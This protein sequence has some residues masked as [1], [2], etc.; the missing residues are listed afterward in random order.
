MKHLPVLKITLLGSAAVLVSLVLWNWQRILERYQTHSALSSPIR[1]SCSR[2][3]SGTI[4]TYLT[5]YSTF[6]CPVWEIGKLR[7]AMPG[8][9]VRILESQIGFEWPPQGR[10]GQKKSSDGV[11]VYSIRSDGSGE[12]TCTF[13]G[14]EFTMDKA[15]SVTIGDHVVDMG[16]GPPTCVILDKDSLAAQVHSIG[17]Q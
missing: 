14:F 9:R 6:G 10:G 4:N 7:F 12:G 15:G 11:L 16:S 2:D 1:H 3:S 5:S 17:T 8:K 13:L